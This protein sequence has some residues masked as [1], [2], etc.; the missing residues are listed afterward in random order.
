MRLLKVPW[1]VLPLVGVLSRASAAQH[2]VA[3]EGQPVVIGDVSVTPVAIPGHTP[4]A[5]GYIFPVKDG[6]RTYTAGL[7]GGSVLIPTKIPDEALQQYVASVEHFGEVARARGVDVELQNHPIYDGAEKGRAAVRRGNEYGA[8]LMQQHPAK[9][10]LIGGIPMPDLDGSL[11]EIGRR[12]GRPIRT[13]PRIPCRLHRPGDAERIPR[14]IVQVVRPER[15]DPVHVRVHH[16]DRRRVDAPAR[17]IPDGAVPRDLDLGRVGV[18]LRLRVE[19]ERPVTRVE[20]ADGGRAV[21]RRRVGEPD[22]VLGIGGHV[23]RLRIVPRNRVLGEPAR[24][25]VQL[26]QPA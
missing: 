19:G 20:P 4:G 24:R 12:P 17:R 5:L 9:F 22:I 10:G 7:F 26:R 13:L 18:E 2:V 6:G 21:R 3:I 1:M 14:R 15:G 11:A 16:A 25:L 23:V 8:K